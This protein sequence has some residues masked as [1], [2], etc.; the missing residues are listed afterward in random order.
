MKRFHDLN[1]KVYVLFLALLAVSCIP[2]QQ[3]IGDAGQTFVKLHPSVY[4]MLA[5]DAKTTPQSGMLFEIRRDVPNNKELNT[6]TTVVLQYDENGAILAKYNTDHKTT[7]VPLPTTLGTVSPAIAGGKLTVNLDAGEIG[8]AIMINVPAA[9]N[10][11]F[12]KNYALAFKVLSVSGTGKLSADVDETIVCEV[13]AKNKW[14]GVYSVTGTFV[15]YINAPWTGIYPKIVELRTTGAATCSKYDTDYGVYGYIFETGGGASQFGAWTPAFIFDASNNVNVVNTSVDSPAR[16]RTAELYTGE[17]AVNKY[18]PA[19]KTMEVGYYLK[20]LN[21][22]PQLRSL[23][24]E[25]YT[26]KGPR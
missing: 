2:E 11:D 15:D 13:L 12:S 24:T 3:S 4:N 8:K 7:Y 5:F 18:F 21:V 25:K 20:Q 1:I 14:D 23:V 22:S 26:Y 9:G 19:T 6:T 16:G 17:G 10:F